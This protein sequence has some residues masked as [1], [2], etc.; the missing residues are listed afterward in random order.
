MTLYPEFTKRLLSIPERI[1]DFYYNRASSPPGFL[2]IVLTIRFIVLLI[3]TINFGYL[4]SVANMPIVKGISAG[5]LWF[6]FLFTV[7]L[8]ALA[9]LKPDEFESYKT[10]TR[11]VVVDAIV[12][13]YFY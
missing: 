9:V 7:Y 8:L 11:Q 12:I 5:V 6:Y 1:L 4:F 2:K 13:A 3:S 10:Q